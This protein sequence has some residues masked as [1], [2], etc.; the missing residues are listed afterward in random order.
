MKHILACA[1][2]VAATLLS[3]CAASSIYR[4]VDAS[5]GAFIST[6]SPVVSVKAAPGY[7]RVVS[8]Y[9]L[10]RVAYENSMMRTI[11]ADAWFSLQAG[12]GSQLVS[13]LAECPSDMIW[14]VRAVGVDF[15]TLK[16]LY[17]H[18][19]ISPNS[20]TVHVYVRPA[21]MDPWTPMF[22]QAGKAAW[23]GDT[24]VA[25]YEWM[26]GADRSKLIVEYRE[27]APELFP[28]ITMNVGQLTDF[29]ERSQK[30]FTLEGV[31]A[32][33]TPMPRNIMNVPDSLLAPVIGVVSN[34]RI[35][36]DI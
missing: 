24:L 27:P 22:A 12:E 2:L 5:S 20:A 13:L 26:G 30:A 33:V 14:E 17:E 10:C 1:L 6:S 36:M 29:I 32:P 21:S 34:G 9:T 4:G 3:G 16:V 23:Q 19:G 7:E 8:G 25:R 11:S 15:Q 28:G 31:T 18:N 35:F